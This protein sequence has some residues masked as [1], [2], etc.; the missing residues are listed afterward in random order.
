MKE[1]DQYF[2]FEDEEK[3]RPKSEYAH[4]VDYE[5][6][7][8][9]GFGWTIGM[10]SLIRMLRGEHAGKIF[11][12]SFIEG[13]FLEGEFKGDEAEIERRKEERRKYYGGK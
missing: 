6:V 10:N 3:P 13:R 9:G 12:T 4:G 7:V 5:V 1:R 11:H 8:L 2:D